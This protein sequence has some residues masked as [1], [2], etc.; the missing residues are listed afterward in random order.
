MPGPPQPQCSRK[1]RLRAAARANKPL[2]RRAQLAPL[3]TAAK[4]GSAFVTDSCRARPLSAAMLANGWCDASASAVPDCSL[5]K[6]AVAYCGSDSSN[7]E[8]R[9]RIG[10]R[11][12]RLVH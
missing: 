1:L 6:R 12:S 3:K 10:R 4:S 5:D 9:A 7:L 11:A 2:G 8:V